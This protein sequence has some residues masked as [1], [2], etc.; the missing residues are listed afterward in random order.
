MI[1]LPASELEIMQAIWLLDEEGEK[2]I[3][4]SLAMKRCPELQ[5]LKLTT[6]LT[7]INRLQVKGF[8]KVQKI[9]HSNGYIPTISSADYRKFAYGDFLEK[10]YLSDKMDLVNALLTTEDFTKEELDE[11][12]ALVKKAEKGEK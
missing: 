3:T 6:V 12:K 5:R 2:F 7:L 8:V 11:I 9:G 10:V 4:A 1:K